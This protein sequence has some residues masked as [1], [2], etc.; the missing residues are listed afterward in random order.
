MSTDLVTIDSQY[1]ALNPSP[2]AKRII[3]ENLQG[4]LDPNQ[5]QRITVPRAGGSAWEVPSASGTDVTQNLLIIILH[6]DQNRKYYEDEYTDGSSSPPSCSSYGG[7]TG[8]GSP[9]GVCADCPMN[10]W[11]SARQG[12][13][14]A[15]REY[16]L[17]YGLLPGQLFP[18][19]VTIPPTG[20]KALEGYA[21]L[22]GNSDRLLSEVVTKIT[23][24]GGVVSFSNNGDLPDAEAE[25]VETYRNGVIDDLRGHARSLSERTEE[26]GL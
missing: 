22:L 25:A 16:R 21:Y 15:C 11:G 23:A 14:K 26:E 1:P 6:L 7:V 3:E 5:I 2:R 10:A 9:G 20:L 18:V 8:V 12:R 19:L 13:G 24:P 4:R 17:V